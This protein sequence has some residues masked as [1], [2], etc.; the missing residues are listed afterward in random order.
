[1]MQFLKEYAFI[2]II[3]SILAAVLIGFVAI[4]RISLTDEHS[5][6]K[7][8][9]MLVARINLSGAKIEIR[10]A[11]TKNDDFLAQT[12]K[13]INESSVYIDNLIGQQ[14]QKII[15]NK[16]LNNQIYEF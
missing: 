7:M 16:L 1:M 12:K 9:A 13:I 11:P 8:A 15:N 3:F 4:I 6:F 10:P 2:L 5:N 14:Y